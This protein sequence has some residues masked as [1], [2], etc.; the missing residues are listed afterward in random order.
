MNNNY[1]KALAVMRTR[2]ADGFV[3]RT[4]LEDRYHFFNDNLEGDT[5]EALAIALAEVRDGFEV[6]VFRRPNPEWADIREMGES[7]TVLS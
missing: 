3:R 4:T 2:Q 1:V 7:P 6:F 5:S